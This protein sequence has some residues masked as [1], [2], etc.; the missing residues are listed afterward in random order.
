MGII[1]I[2]VVLT[3]GLVV[4]H[5]VSSRTLLMK[6]LILV[7]CLFLIFTI[8]AAVQAR[9]QVKSDIEKYQKEREWTQHLYTESL[10]LGDPTIIRKYRSSVIAWNTFVK[11]TKEK[12]ESFWTD[13]YYPLELASSLEYIEVVDEPTA[14]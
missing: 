10:E 3:G 5:N 7:S 11:N 14:S 4:L 1:V 9:L 8:S 6:F 13:L 2:A 12:S